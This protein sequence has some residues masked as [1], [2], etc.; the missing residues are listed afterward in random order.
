MLLLVYMIGCGNNTR[1]AEYHNIPTP[2]D[3]LHA[4]VSLPRDRDTHQQSIRNPGNS[5]MRALT[6]Y[7]PVVTIFTTDFN[8]KKTLH[9]ANAVQLRVQYDDQKSNCCSR[10]SMSTESENLL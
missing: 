10:N 3:R 5:Q 9:F 1:N 4:G 7:S 2:A 8:I 6:L